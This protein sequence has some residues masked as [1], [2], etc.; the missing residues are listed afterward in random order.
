MK[1]FNETIAAML[2]IAE[3]KVK[4]LGTDKILEF[5]LPAYN[6]CMKDEKLGIDYIYDLR[7]KEDAM[8]LIKQYPINTDIQ[9]C[10]SFMNDSLV[11]NKPYII[12]CN[13]KYIA[14]QTNI[15]I[16]ILL[17]EAKEILYYML[18]LPNIAEYNALY[19]QIFYTD[20]ENF[21]NE[22]NFNQICIM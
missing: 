16:D 22:T 19:T 12:I 13:N 8:E 2:D 7:K 6:R 17:K 18:L 21:Y 3:E 11:S 5:L 15:I 4:S 1:N 20:M 10:I 14:Y 9:N